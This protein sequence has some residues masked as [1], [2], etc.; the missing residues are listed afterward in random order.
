LSDVG[1]CIPDMPD[2][3]LLYKAAFGQQI[4]PDGNPAD[5]PLFADLFNNTDNCSESPHRL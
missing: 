2:F 1:A 5:R 4:W 3:N